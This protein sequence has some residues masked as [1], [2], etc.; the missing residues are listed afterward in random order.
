[1]NKKSMFLNALKDWFANNPYKKFTYA[2]STIGDDHSLA[3]HVF[4]EPKDSEGQEK[5]FDIELNHL[6]K[7]EVTASFKR[8]LDEAY[9]ETRT[10][11]ICNRDV[12]SW[13]LFKK[14]LPEEQDDVEA[15]L[16]PKRRDEYR[17]KRC[18]LISPR[19][20]TEVL[21]EIRKNKD[22]E[23]AEKRS[24][25]QVKLKEQISN[26]SDSVESNVREVKLGGLIQG[27]M[28]VEN[29]VS[30]RGK[31]AQYDWSNLK[32]LYEKYGTDYDKI[33]SEIGCTGAAVR[34][35]INLGKFE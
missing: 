19:S 30:R 3:F 9:D 35:R 32:D 33:A 29:N 12:H 22:K 8:W 34:R 31:K 1:M 10:Y 7:S 4:F 13:S 18:K 25:A 5:M 11:E 6:T 23:A 15:I 24:Q 20:M 16:D 27:T 2:V 14:A 21:E 17:A 26:V 28:I